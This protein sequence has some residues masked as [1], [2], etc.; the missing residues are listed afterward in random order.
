M[1]VPSSCTDL[2]Q[3]LDL[4]VNKPLKDHL[5]R[6]FQSWYSEQVSKQLEEGKEP[7]DVKVDTRLTIMKPFGAKWITSAYDYLRSESG[8]VRGG[9]IEA[10]IV[11]ALDEDETE[12]QAESDEDPFQDLD[13][14]PLFTFSLY[15]CMHMC[16]I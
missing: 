4:L 6:S 2:L 7:E 9:F 11:Q 5:R 8:I 15:K 3:P 13:C 12:D 10:G 1:I 16:L 14:L